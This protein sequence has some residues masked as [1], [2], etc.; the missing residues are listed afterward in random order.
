[1]TVV[2]MLQQVSLQ[3]NHVLIENDPNIAKLVQC[4]GKHG[5]CDRSVA[6]KVANRSKDRVEVYKCPHCSLYHIGRP[7]ANKSRGTK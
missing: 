6:N 1:M 7:V 5:F 3:D 2:Y 4:T